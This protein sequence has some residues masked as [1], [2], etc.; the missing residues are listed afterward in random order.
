MVDSDLQCI[1]RA[2]VEALHNYEVLKKQMASKM[3]I[4]QAHDP[5]FDV[6]IDIGEGDKIANGSRITGITIYTMEVEV[7]HLTYR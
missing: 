2:F 3:V 7:V 5:D 6:E 4:F 1:K